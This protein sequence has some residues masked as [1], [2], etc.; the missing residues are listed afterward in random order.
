MLGKFPGLLGYGGI[1]AIHADWPNYPSGIGWEIALKSLGNFPLGT[2]FYEVDDIDRCKLLVNEDPQ[3]L[4]DY[5]DYKHFHSAIWHSDLIELQ[6]KGLIDGV[7][8]KSD[9]EF[10]LIRF[11]EFKEQLGKNLQEDN[12]GNIILTSKNEDGECEELIYKKPKP[13]EDQIDFKDCAFIPNDI[14]LT[15]LGIQVL[16]EL[17]SAVNLSAEIYQLTG[18]LI[19]ILRYDTAIREASLFIETSIKEFHGNNLYGQ[20]LIDYH[21]NKTVSLNDNFFSSAIKC[22]RGELRTIFKF[23]RNDYAHNF[24]VISLDQCIMVLNRINDTYLEF[25]EV[26]KVYYGGK[27]I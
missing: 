10:E 27:N 9:D 25:Q 16:S 18:P 21:I 22:Y 4:K 6:R 17:S 20:K 14:I 13:S 8:A 23:I 12:F 5:Y 19:K 24:K 11:Q 2:K 26:K 7:I 15:S 3:N 1:I